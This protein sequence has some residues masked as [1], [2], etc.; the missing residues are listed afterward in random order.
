MAKKRQPSAKTRVAKQHATDHKDKTQDKT[1]SAQPVF[2]PSGAQDSPLLK[3]P[4]E[5][6]NRVYEYALYTDGQCLITKA[7]GIPEPSLL[8]TSKEIR[9][10]AIGI[11]YSVNNV[12]LDILSFDATALR[13]F[14]RKVDAM[15]TTSHG[16]RI[17][18]SGLQFRSAPNWTNLKG[19]LRY[20]HKGD[21]R[22][23]LPFAEFATDDA[24]GLPPVFKAIYGMIRCAAAMQTSP[25]EEVESTFELLR[26]GLILSDARWGTT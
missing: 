5:L 19:M 23:A 1:K 22:F 15:A 16:F 18:G 10:E 4:A 12:M 2:P 21:N 11:Y 14:D 20:Y 26:A 13:H 24:A 9:K 7:G 6:R 25:W 17:S 3:L 8:T